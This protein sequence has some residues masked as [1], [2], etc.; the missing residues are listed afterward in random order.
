V[1]RVHA[2][3]KAGDALRMMAWRLTCDIVT[4]EIPRTQESAE[5]WLT[6]NAL[7]FGIEFLEDGSRQLAEGL[8]DALS[9][10]HE[11]NDAA[12]SCKRIPESG[13]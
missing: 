8:V 9:S 1:H 2:D 12:E 3:A 6:Q 5:S 10:E 13:F 11:K 7:R 4:G